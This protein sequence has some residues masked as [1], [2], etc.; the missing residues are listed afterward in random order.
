VRGRRRPRLVVATKNPGKL[1]EIRALLADLDVEWCTLRD[2]PS[3]VLPEEGDDYAENALEKARSAA[4]QS[5]EV[6][7]ADD[8]GLEVA[9]LDGRPGPHSARYGGPGLDDAGRV[10]RLLEEMRPLTGS[11]RSARFVCVAAVASPSGETAEARGECPGRILEAPRGEQGFGYDP[12]FESTERNAP[13]AE[14]P[15]AEKNRISH[16]GRAFAALREAIDA[17]LGSAHR[18][19]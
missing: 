6:A 14:L 19:R 15:E 7:I 9:G 3:V 1:R 4:R 18:G 13:M 17:Q 5:G 11:Q 2:F 12:V 10:R 16:R 8:S